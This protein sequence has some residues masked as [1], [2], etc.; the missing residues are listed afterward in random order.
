MS[1]NPV[2]PPGK[3]VFLIIIIAVCPRPFKS[4][5]IA[6][7]HAIGTTI[8]LDLKEKNNI[9]TQYRQIRIFIPM[10]RGCEI[11]PIGLRFLK[12]VFTS[13]I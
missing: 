6:K 4:I 2:I 9:T 1:I 7:I 5:A 11:S 8:G 13:S 12:S 10:K 3:Y